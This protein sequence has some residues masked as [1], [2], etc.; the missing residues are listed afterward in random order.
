VS[1]HHLDQYATVSSP[2][3]RAT[4]T[5]R[6]LA[7]TAIAVGTA[8]LPLGAW[9]HLGILGGL[10]VLFAAAAHVPASLILRRLAGPFVF[11][12]AA[13]T[14]LLFLV[15]GTPLIHVGPFG[16]SDAGLQR[17]GFVLG[18]AS[19]AL[20]AAVI[21]VSTTSFPE[22]VQALRQLRLPAAVTTALGLGYRLL[23]LLVDELERLQRAAR[24]RNAGG[25]TTRRRRLLVGIAA[26]GLARAFSRG[27]RT[28]RAML[29][30]GFVGDLPSLA[31]KSWDLGTALA[32]AVLIVAVIAIALSA[33]VRS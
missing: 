24:S 10:V 3:T 30:R 8:A 17:F 20:T 25:G 1:F 28:H 31:P 2:V 27:E 19:V 13:S 4:P 22:L 6:V 26:A 21:L 16:I 7:A 12:L 9:E 14:G 11:V 23:Y 33:H 29:A 15:P 32:L 5:A 18:R